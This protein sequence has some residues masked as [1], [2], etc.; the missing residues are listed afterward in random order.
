MATPENAV[1]YLCALITEEFVTAWRELA[2]PDLTPEI[3]GLPVNCVD[4]GAQSA[5]RRDQLAC[6]LAF[7]A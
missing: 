4:A 3:G 7:S 6:A 2:G 5:E 1:R